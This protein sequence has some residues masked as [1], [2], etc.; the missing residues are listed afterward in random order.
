M[1]QLAEGLSRRGHSVIA[2]SDGGYGAEEGPAYVEASSLVLDGAECD[3][4]ITCGATIPP[5]SIRCDRHV[6]LW[7]HDPVAGQ[8]IAYLESAGLR[9]AEF[10]CVSQ[11]QA[12]RFPRGWRTRVVPAMIDDWIYDLP[13]TERRL[14]TYACVSA[15]W[16]GTDQTLALWR[17]AHEAGV[18]A[19]DTLLVGSQY[20]Q[21]DD[22]RARVE[23]TP[24]CEWVEQPNPRAVVDVLRTVQGVFRVSVHSETFGVTDTIAQIVGCRTHVLTAA[25]QGGLAESL[26]PND[27]VSSTPE[28]LF[29][30]MRA[31]A[32]PVRARDFRASRIV[33]RW[34]R[35]LGL[36]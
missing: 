24:G 28:E 19:G 6:V 11:W 17:S 7:T 12:D 18:L 25:P 2:A 4:L 23:A 36:S 20:S 3:V 34:E 26:S 22:A 35:G 21:P 33:S 30:K 27:D 8:N 31:Y 29:R 14:R 16:K 5:P 13:P 1:R 15:W 10:V 9:W 32:S